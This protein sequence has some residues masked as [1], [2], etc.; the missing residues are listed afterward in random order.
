MNYMTKF[1]LPINK[2]NKKNNNQVLLFS[3]N[4]QLQRPAQIFDKLLK[5]ILNF[6]HQ[7]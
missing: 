2:F 6:L 3:L 4:K 5:H 7:Y 1:Y